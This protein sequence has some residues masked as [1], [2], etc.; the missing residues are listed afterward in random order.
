MSFCTTD[1]IAYLLEKICDRAENDHNNAVYF[2]F[3]YLF[4]YSTY[5][6][7][8][9]IYILRKGILCTICNIQ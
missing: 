1:L 3:T 7:I 9:C 2:H 5:N 8:Y 4:V 6:P